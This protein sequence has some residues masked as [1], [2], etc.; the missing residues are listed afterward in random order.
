MEFVNGKWHGLATLFRNDTCNTKCLEQEYKKGK[1]DGWAT[2]FAQNGNIWL[3]EEYKDDVRGGDST[4]YHENGLKVWIKEKY[5]KG[6]RIFY[7]TKN[8]IVNLENKFET[9][10]EPII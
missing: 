6:L 3:T 4:Y 8:I 1:K 10:K 5:K 2:Y 7:S 9:T